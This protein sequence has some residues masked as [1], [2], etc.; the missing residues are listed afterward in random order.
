MPLSQLASTL[1]I[2]VPQGAEYQAVCRGLIALK[3]SGRSKNPQAI[4][5]PV[6]P[7]P[8]RRR[9]KDLLEAGTL[10]TTVSSVLVMGLCGS[11]NPAYSV[12]T[13]VIYQN[14]L[15]A[16]HALLPCDSTLIA[17][18]TAQLSVQVPLVSGFTSERLVWSHQ[19]KHEL[20]QQYQADVVDMEGF[21]ILQTLAQ[22]GVPVAMVR[23]VSDNATHDI[24]NLTAAISPEGA[25]QP[26]ALALGML[27]QPFAALRLM[28][29]SL[30]GLSVLERTAKQL[31]QCLND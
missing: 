11:L 20:H 12:G 21:A 4:A 22:V 10:Q 3:G 30:Q 16:S 7:E 9:L 6:G 8:V 2:L 25:L 23:V 24:P 13:A 5:L 14:C 15:T 29:G 26:L 18:V 27:R 31:V 1:V 17:A 19:T 28:R